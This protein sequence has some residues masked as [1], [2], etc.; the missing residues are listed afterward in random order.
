MS[1]CVVGDFL[2]NTGLFH[3]L[4]ENLIGGRTGRKFRENKRIVI[5]IR[6]PLRQPLD[7]ILRERCIN[8]SGCHFCCTVAIIYLP[9]L[10][11]M[12]FQRSVSISLRRKSAITRKQIRL[13]H[14]HVT[15]FG[16]NEKFHFLD[17]KELA[18]RF[19][20]LYTLRSRELHERIFAQPLRSDCGIQG[21]GELG[22]IGH[23]RSLF[24]RLSLPAFIG[25]LQ[26][27]NEA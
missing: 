22:D 18:F 8:G 27:V 17:G 21:N 13:L 10:H 20:F 7:G 1:C 5:F 19:R 23:D 9:S 3:P 2:V 12:S 25:M 15:T 14:R 4:F 11:I 24:K 16:S 6:F 26:P